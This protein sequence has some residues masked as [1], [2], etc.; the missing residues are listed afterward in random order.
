M[1]FGITGNINRAEIRD[2]IS[3]AI[4]F[5]DERGVSWLIDSKFGDI[6][7]GKDKIADLKELGERCDIILTYGGDGS[8]LYVSRELT[9]MDTPILGL[10]MGHLGFLT[11]IKPDE[12][13]A[14]IDDIL[15]GNYFVENRAMLKA[16]ELNSTRKSHYAVNDI[17][18][19]KGEH[20]RIMKIGLTINDDY[21]HTYVSNGLI[22]STATGSTAYSL[23]A[24][25]PIFYPTI[26]N[27]LVTP[28]CPHTLSMR[29]MVI[30]GEFEITLEVI[31]GPEKIVL[32]ADGEPCCE[33]KIGE[34]VLIKRIPDEL[35]LIHFKEHTF[36]NVL[37]SKLGWGARNESE[38]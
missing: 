33:L 17:V 4:R 29:P 31:S 14:R 12:L 3:K 30:P 9:N 10:N 18:I 1:I 7:G 24:G 32:Q 2:V 36:F 23:S 25:G 21:V 28:I 15:N 27:I 34:R 26:D 22:V 11:E 5:L 8:L 6:G 35:K 13:P 16:E 20:S 37:S 38:F 19:D